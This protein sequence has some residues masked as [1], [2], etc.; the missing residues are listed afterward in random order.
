[1]VKFIKTENR[2]MTPGNGSRQKWGVMNQ[3]S[4]LIHVIPAA[5]EVEIRR[6]VVQGILGIKVK[7]S[8]NSTNKVCMVVH[9]CGLSYVEGHR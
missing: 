7:E 8:P 3:A 6:M 2:I 1:V 4:W 5:W 9:A